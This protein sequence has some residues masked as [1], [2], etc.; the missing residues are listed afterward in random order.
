MH[1]FGEATLEV[2]RESPPVLSD[3]QDPITVSGGL[4]VQRQRNVS[5]RENESE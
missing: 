5:V 1:H 2:H 4:D 3:L